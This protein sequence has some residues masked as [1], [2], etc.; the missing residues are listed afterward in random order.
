MDCAV[1]ASKLVLQ[2]LTHITN[3]HVAKGRSPEAGGLSST[4]KLLWGLRPM[5]TVIDKVCECI[6]R[7]PTSYIVRPWWHDLHIHNLS[8]LHKREGG[9]VTWKRRIWSQVKMTFFRRCLEAEVHLECHICACERRTPILLT[10]QLSRWPYYSSAK[11]CYL[12]LE[13]WIN[14]IS[15]GEKGGAENGGNRTRIGIG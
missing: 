7:H 13:I 12:V 15:P 4:R 1:A 14:D 5:S 3:I 6:Q 9:E 11:W 10:I 2:T 8:P